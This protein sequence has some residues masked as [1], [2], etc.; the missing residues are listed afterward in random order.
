ML[1]CLAQ[2]KQTNMEKKPKQKTQQPTCAGL[3]KQVS[4]LANTVKA[5][6]AANYQNCQA[7]G[8]L[9]KEVAPQSLMPTT[10]VASYFNYM[11][12]NMNCTVPQVIE[13]LRA[14]EKLSTGALNSAVLRAIA[15][16]LDARYNDNIRNCK[17][18]F[19]YSNT[20]GK[21]YALDK[22]DIK[23]YTSVAAFRTMEDAQFAVKMLTQIKQAI[24]TKENGKD[25]K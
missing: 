21:I 2:I 4:E 23:N 11:A 14:I 24:H 20:N 6:M 17:K 13:H 3:Q 25:G 12:G 9:L 5:L 15:I 22:E 10:N 1:N 18:V 16:I 19:T 7:I 8:F